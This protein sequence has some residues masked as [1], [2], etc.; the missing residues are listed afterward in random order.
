MIKQ[1]NAKK[2]AELYSPFFPHHVLTNSNGSA[3]LPRAEFY[4]WKNQI[5]EKNDVIFL[6]TDTQAQTVEG[7]YD[8]VNCFLDYAEEIGVKTIVTIGGYSSKNQETSSGVVCVS[9]SKE[10]LK[11]ILNAGAEI[12]PVGN[13]IVGLA[14]LT[15]GLSRLRGIDATC[16]LGETTGH[17]PDPAVSKKVL[18]IIQ[19]FL[20]I[21]IE[22]EPL[23]RE[24]EKASRTLKKMECVQ[25]KMNDLV[26]KSLELET[27]KVTYIT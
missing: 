9:T 1:L 16:I 21:D 2:L 6:T 22:V 8:V 3:R 27:R 7:H 4:F 11:R 14:G 15:I 24:I 12:S 5:K 10:L 17:M 26:K 19:N 20:Q 18:K 13:P 25:Q 23:D